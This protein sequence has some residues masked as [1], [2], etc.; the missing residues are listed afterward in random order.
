MKFVDW[1]ERGAWPVAA[2]GLV[3]VE[4]VG[5][6]LPIKAQVARGR[7]GLDA[8]AGLDVTPAELARE[9]RA[10]LQKRESFA[11]GL[12]NIQ[13]VGQKPLS[14]AA[15]PAAK[16]GPRRSERAYHTDQFDKDCITCFRAFA[17]TAMLRIATQPILQFHRN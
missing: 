7:C 6:D 10:Q 14:R 9:E 8:E 11:L 15:C 5:R 4:V 3:V 2:R 12:R 16:Q 13:W 17:L 1:L